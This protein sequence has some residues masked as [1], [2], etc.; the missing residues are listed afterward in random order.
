VAAPTGSARAP[1]EGR[2]VGA[3]ELV[4]G[5]VVGRDPGARIVAAAWPQERPRL[6]G[7]SAEV[8]VQAVLVGAIVGGHRYGRGRVCAA[9]SFPEAEVGTA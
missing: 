9:P 3:S 1:R 6:Q 5:V 4:T 8:L 2:V 7:T